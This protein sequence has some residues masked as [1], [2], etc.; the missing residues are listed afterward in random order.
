VNPALIVQQEEVQRAE[1]EKRRIREDFIRKKEHYE[2][3]I[4]RGMNIPQLNADQMR[5]MKVGLIDLFKGELNPM[6]EQM[7][8]EGDDHAEWLGFEGAYKE[9]MY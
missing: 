8:T 9:S 5:R 2:R 6:L 7:M 3:E 1:A 4:S